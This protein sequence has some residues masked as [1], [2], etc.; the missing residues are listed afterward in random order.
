MR[1]VIIIIVVS[2][3]VVEDH[4]IGV[5]RGIRAACEE[6]ACLNPLSLLLTRAIG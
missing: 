6:R 1:D 4:L 5:T 3:E 2:R